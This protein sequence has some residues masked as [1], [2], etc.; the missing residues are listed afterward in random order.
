MMRTWIC[1]T[2]S[3]SPLYLSTF[4]A[5]ITLKAEIDPRARRQETTEVPL[6]GDLDDLFRRIALSDR[7][8]FEALYHKT[9]GKLMAVIDRILRDPHESADVLQEVF[10]K[11]WHQAQTYAGTGSAWGWLT[12]MA[13]NAALDRLRSLQRKPEDTREDT[14]LLLQTMSDNLS[15]PADSHGLQQCLS[16]L[17][18]DAREAI[19]LSYVHGYSHSDLSTKM[20]KPLGTLKAWIRRGL[21]ELKKCLSA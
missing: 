14:D 10:V 6:F 4:R 11:V 12:V 7:K 17:S 15:C 9:S 19:L 18:P 3:R 1:C 13:R 2:A 16:Q 21:L 5:G 8:A 20:Q